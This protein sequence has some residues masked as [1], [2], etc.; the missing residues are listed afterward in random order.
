RTTQRPPCPYLA[1]SLLVPHI[2]HCP[3]LNVRTAADERVWPRGDPRLRFR[4]SPQV[5]VPP[6][7]G[8][9]RTGPVGSGPDR[10]DHI[11]TTLNEASAHAVSRNDPELARLVIPSRPLQYEHAR[12]LRG[13]LNAP[14]E[15]LKMAAAEST[16]TRTSRGTTSSL[17]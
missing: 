16:S 5:G 14:N 1:H 2:E 15:F 3:R 13:S 6:R 7:P 11:P 9:I 10:T 8:E 4:S 17:R 12:C